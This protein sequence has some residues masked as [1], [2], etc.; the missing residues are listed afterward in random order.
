MPEL[1]FR[2]WVERKAEEAGSSD[3]ALRQ[4]EWKRA[5]NLL[6]SRIEG[7][8]R[9]EGGDRIA[10]ED[11]VVQRNE[12]GMGI[13]NIHGLR[14]RIGDS[15]AHVVPV[16]RNVIARIN[17]PGGGELPG[18]GRVDIIG[19]EKKYHLY[20]TIEDGEDRWYVVDPERHPLADRA[21]EPDLP[22]TREH[23]ER[24]LMDLMS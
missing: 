12:R 5:Y 20:R 14:I 17:P 22:L 2:E 4:S 8:L 21:R 23:F 10:I 7:W 16:G 18:A 19:G 9:E 13:Y 6:R 24:I 1:S 3:R 11:E 15:L